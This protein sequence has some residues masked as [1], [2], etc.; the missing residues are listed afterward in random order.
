MRTGI[1]ELQLKEMQEYLPVMDRKNLNVSAVTVGWHIS[2]SLKVLRKVFQLLEDSDPEDY[3]KQFSFLRHYIF[4]FR[5]IPRGK[6][7]APSAVLP[8][9]DLQ[10]SVLE[11]EIGELRD[12]LPQLK[13]LPKKA[14]YRHHMFGDLDRDQTI[15]FLQ[16]HTEHHLKIIR[17]ILK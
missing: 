1:I 13:E 15:R 8:D 14:F 17:D 12:Q 2:H 6:A 16:I 9:K 4:L 10:A 5:R 7:K 3:K 11:I